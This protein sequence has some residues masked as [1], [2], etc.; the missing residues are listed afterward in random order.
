[1]IVQ[2]VRMTDSFFVGKNG[3]LQA[4]EI[5]YGCRVPYTDVRCS[6]ICY[7]TNEKF[8]ISVATVIEQL[9]NEYINVRLLYNK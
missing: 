8:K 6:Q 5:G 7:I 4:G 1:M 9:Y 2:A 3:V